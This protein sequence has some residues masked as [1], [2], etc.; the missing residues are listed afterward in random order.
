MKV[1]ITFLNGIRMKMIAWLNPEVL[2][3]KKRTKGMPPVEIF[4]EL[5]QV[6]K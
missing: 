2:S 5:E 4:Y 3:W 6:S 1:K